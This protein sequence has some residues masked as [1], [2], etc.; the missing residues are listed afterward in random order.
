M[1]K[2]KQKNIVLSLI[3]RAGGATTMD[4]FRNHILSGS[5]RITDLRRDGHPIVTEHVPDQK[6]MCY[7]YVA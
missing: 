3:K 5:R 1:D 4:F 2:T 6:Y 7:K